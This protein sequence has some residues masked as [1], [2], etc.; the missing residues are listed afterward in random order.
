MEGYS[1]SG[2]RRGFCHFTSLW[3]CRR[4]FDGLFALQPSEGW[5]QQPIAF[6]HFIKVS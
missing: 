2:P 3:N 6:G 4:S 1:A 5:G